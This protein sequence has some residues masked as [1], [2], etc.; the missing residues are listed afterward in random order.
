MIIH[1]HQ[2]LTA[3]KQFARCVRNRPPL[4]AL[5]CIHISRT[6]QGTHLYGTDLEIALRFTMPTP[7]AVSTL[8]RL[9]VRRG[10][11]FLVPLETLRNCAQAADPGS[12]LTITEKAITFEMNGSPAVVPTEAPH[13]DEFPAFPDLPTLRVQGPLDTIALARCARAMSTAEA[14]YVLNGILWK[15]ITLVATDGRR[16]HLENTATACPT[17]AILPSKLIPLILPGMEALVGTSTIAFTGHC[18]GLQVTLFSKLVQGHYPNYQQVLPDPC[19]HGF[20]LDHEQAAEALHKLLAT[21]PTH[22][23]IIPSPGRITLRTNAGAATTLPALLTGQP[24]ST[25]VNGKFLLDAFRN[26]GRTITYP[27]AMTPLR[28]TGHL[29]NIHVLMPLRIGEAVTTTPAT[30]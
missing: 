29:D 3:C 28:V 30:T 14:R 13:P 10:Y 26:G 20:R 15:G 27:D 6:E 25:A 16:L 23:E 7:P 12:S 2:L 22:V 17:E 4:P 11:A 21:K 1:K 18:E 19:D 24:C 5:E 9:R 8:D